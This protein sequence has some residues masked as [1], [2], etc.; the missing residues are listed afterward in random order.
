MTASI[1]AWDTRN[2]I[3]KK[4]ARR[5]TASGGSSWKGSDRSTTKYRLCTIRPLEI[6]ALK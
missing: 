3:T 6:L 4:A 2:S 5:K 1:A